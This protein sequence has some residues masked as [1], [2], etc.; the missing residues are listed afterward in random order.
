MKSSIARRSII[1]A[2]AAAAVA[3]LLSLGTG[4]SRAE[5]P[6][7]SQALEDKEACIKNLK[8][9][10]QALQAYQTDHKDLPNWLSDLVPQ[11]LPDANVLI[12]PVC[13][14]TGETESPPLADP[15][16]PSSYLFQ[17]CPVPLGKDAPNAPSQ[18]RRE[19]KRRQMGL[20]GSVVPVVRCHHH[21]PLLNLA[22]DGVI[23]ES[24]GMWE[25]AFT[26]RVSPQSLTAA[27]LF[28]NDPPPGPKNQS[29]PRF[30]ARNPKTEPGLINLSK[31]YNAALTESWHGGAGNDL[32]ALPHGLQ[33]FDGVEFD[34]RGI[35]QLGSLSPS[36][37]KY[38]TEIKG[39]PVNQKCQHLSFLHAAGFGTARD[40]GKQLG[41]YVVHF[42]TNH[43]R[44]D[45]PI[46][47]G[48]EM[49]NWHELPDEPT[50]PNGLSVAWTGTN[51]VSK[52]VGRAIRL[53]K[54]TWT[55]PMPGVVIESIDL[56]SGLATPAPFL[57]AIT[58]E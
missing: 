56:V 47:Y 16:I 28:A 32:A 8:L 29:Q 27:R 50:A 13:R 58:A 33:T 41:A 48:R 9:I 11:Y 23:Y 53:F 37:S 18:T 20:V 7:R 21:K 49:R 36:A 17:F 2:A 12:C 30:P 54:T 55:N 22:F 5:E 19:W 38:P 35:V 14:R 43:M 26:N 42:A 40:E 4:A 51:A 52:H 39:I 44:L 10:Y 6:A 45:I 24:P 31:F 25:M 1:V 46:Y 3:A 57:I 15:K 34:V